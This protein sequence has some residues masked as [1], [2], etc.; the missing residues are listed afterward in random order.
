[1]ARQRFIKSIVA[2]ANDTTTPAMPWSR[3][4]RRQALIANRAA[5][6]GESTEGMQ[7]TA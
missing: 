2:A 6:D 7:K 1:M 4:P 5:P 3:G